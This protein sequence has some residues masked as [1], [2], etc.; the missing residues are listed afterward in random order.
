MSFLLTKNYTT[1]PSNCV[2]VKVEPREVKV[3][4]RKMLHENSNHI[5][6]SN[7]GFKMLLGLGWSGELSNALNLTITINVPLII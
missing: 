1:A 5:D 3:V 6:Q 4:K 7:I 2:T